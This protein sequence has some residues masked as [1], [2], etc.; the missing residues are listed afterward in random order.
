MF[1]LQMVNIGQQITREML[2]N[3]GAEHSRE[4]RNLIID[5]NV[6]YIHEEII[7]QAKEGS[8]TLNITLA[9]LMA[10]TLMNPVLYSFFN[11]NKKNTT[12]IEKY[13]DDII[14]KLKETFIDITFEYTK[15]TELRID[16]L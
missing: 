7:R 14:M 2:R 6:K 5:S 8:T 13:M 4:I 3:A 15:Q 16:W 10:K 9:L 12:I 11:H 1:L